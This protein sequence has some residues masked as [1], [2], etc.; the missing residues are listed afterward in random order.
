MSDKKS[1]SPADA[2]ETDDPTMAAGPSVDQPIDPRVRDYIE[3]KTKELVQCGKAKDDPKDD[4]DIVDGLA[5][6]RKERWKL[7]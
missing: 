6:Y 1:D 5:A 2:D 4:P 7:D 3:R